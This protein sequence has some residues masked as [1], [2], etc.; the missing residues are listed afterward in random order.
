LVL[1]DHDVI[2]AEEVVPIHLALNHCVH[3][4]VVRQL[5]GI[6][7]AQTERAADVRKVSAVRVRVRMIARAEVLVHARARTCM[8]VRVCVRVRVRAC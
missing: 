5:C 1:D 4:D 7:I 2:I 6:K 8:T 3:V